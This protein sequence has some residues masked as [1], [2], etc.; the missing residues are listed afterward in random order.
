MDGQ[1]AKIVTVCECIDL[2]MV[3]AIWCDDFANP[4]PDDMIMSLG[5]GFDLVSNAT[6]LQ[7]FV[8]LRKLD[9]FFGGENPRSDD[10]VASKF[11][12]DEPAVLGGAG[13]TFLQDAEREDI[14]KCVVHLTERL[15]LDLDS[16]V[17]LQNIINRSIPVFL[18]LVA[19][20]RKVDTQQGAADWLN[21]TEVLIKRMQ[22]H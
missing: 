10:L 2:C 9:D 8:A 3:F 20:F 1:S 21:R 11:G 13:K 5:R 15:S 18:N 6:R 7:S 22:A 16:E 4:D 19:E 14:N 12:I 17:D